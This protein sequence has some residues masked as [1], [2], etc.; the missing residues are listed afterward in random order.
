MMN[1]C[2]SVKAWGSRFA[3]GN[4]SHVFTGGDPFAGDLGVGGRHAT[5]FGWGVEAEE[6]FDR[7]VEQFGLGAEPGLVLGMG[8]EMQQRRP[9]RRPGRI[10]SPKEQ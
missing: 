4:E 2:A 8:G 7:R 10:D 5:D 6:F 1:R 9:E 3:A